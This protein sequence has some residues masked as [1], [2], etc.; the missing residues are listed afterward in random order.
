[1]DANL[2]LTEKFNEGLG[3]ILQTA[4]DCIGASSGCILV[5]EEEKLR[6]GASVANTKNIV[7]AIVNTNT[8]DSPLSK[9]FYPREPLI[10]NE[11]QQDSRFHDYI[12]QMKINNLGE[13]LQELVEIQSLAIIPLEFHREHQGTLV[14]CST[15]IPRL[16]TEYDVSALEPICFRTALMIH[17]WRVAQAEEVKKAWEFLFADWAHYLKTPLTTLKGSIERLTPIYRQHVAAP[18]YADMAEHEVANLLNI[19]DEVFTLSKF[20][21]GISIIRTE[22]GDIRE[23]IRTVRDR[24]RFAAEENSIDIQI[25]APK[26]PI[27]IH[28]DVNRIVEVLY[29]IVINAIQYS[30][31][32]KKVDIFCGIEDDSILFKVTDRGVGIAEEDISQIFEKFWMKDKYAKGTGIG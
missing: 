32:G 14:L 9:V 19:M 25:D 6:V 7:Q 4:M 21:A 26:Q 17:D 5:L 11:A 10:L 30:H 18:Y 8:I 12:E 13:Y 27:T 2:A 23:I 15:N 3:I 31:K 20:S 1:M 24:V 28:W 16:F 22:E 29:N